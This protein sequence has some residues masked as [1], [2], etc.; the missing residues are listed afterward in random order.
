MIDRFR[1]VA[2]AL[3]AVLLLGV[4]GAAAQT[5]QSPTS[6]NPGAVSQ[7][8]SPTAQ[9]PAQPAGPA[10]P[11]INIA[12][13]T[14]RANRDV[15]VNIETA[16]NGWQHELDRLESALQ[17]PR[18]RYSELNDL[19]DELQRVRAG[20]EDFWKR[21]EPR[22][23][24][25]KDQVALL[26][27]A[28]A[29][30]QPPEPEQAALNRAELNY[31]FGLLSAGQAAVHS[32]NLRI[33]HLINTI[34]DIR[35]KNFT[36][37][38]FQPV[39]GIYSYQT[40][41]KLPDYVPSATNRVRD[42][43]ADWWD[44]IRDRNEVLLI[45]FETVLLWLVLTVAAW[46]GV[47]RLRRWRHEG[48]PPF[49]RRAS[50]AAGIILLRILPVVAPI[51][52]LYGMIAEAHALPERVDWIFYS[53]A[54][55]IIII[56]AVN[57]LVTTVFAP[58]SSQWRLIPASDQAA[59]RICGLVL[60]LA[61]V[62]GVT[63]LIYVITRLVQAPFAL[64]VA[65]ALPASLLLAGIVVAILLTP[66][67]GQHWDR[68]PSLRWLTALRIP[69]WITVAAIV[70]CALGG[71]LA[72]SR[73]LAQQLIVTG[74][75][76]AFV[77][78]LLLWVDGFMQG[79]GDDSAATGRWLKE[80]AGLERRRREQL[81]LPIGLFLKFAVLVFSV[82]LILLQW[83][84]RWPDI[85]DWYSQLF[86][87]FQIGNTQVSFAV[88]LAS[89]IVFGLAY[90]ATRLFQGWLD[91]RI[92]KPAGI[93]GGVR[94]SIRI[95]VGY[96]GIVIAGLA[97]FSY[98]G[99]NLS[100]LAILAGALSVGI[101]FG[102]QSVVNNFVS[103][104][105]LLAER[106][107][108]VGD[109]VVVGGEEGYVRKI[110]VRSTEVETS[111]RARVLIPNSYFITEKVKNW[112]LRDNTRRIVI[113]ISVGYGCDPRKVRAT[114]LKVAQ[115][116]P[117]VMTTPA[118]SVDFDFGADTLNFKV[119]AFVDDLSKGGSTSTD[120]RIAILDA[121]NEAGIA[122][123]FRQTDAT[124]QNTDWLR[125]AV[126]EYMAGSHNGTASGNGKASGSTKQ[127]SIPAI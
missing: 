15:G 22:L 28:P 94:D 35:R 58:R 24:A 30:G 6:Q 9:A 34:Q 21:L 107:I 11:Q 66:L 50:S 51:T 57:A 101:G 5:A 13:I 14:A 114:L 108:K 99:F 85:Y 37:N 1:D 67:D 7:A 106:P 36:T 64:T 69:I 122:M 80:R 23:A 27:P 76:L 127:A 102:L 38:L 100:N 49:W 19:R 126:A 47:R 83:G 65:V 117:D 77:Y 82:P 70:V 60:T 119:Y 81:V 98:A 2:R 91:A 92:L 104:L 3:V 118:P 78:L 87:G 109:L 123:P 20:I 115:D 29:A 71:Y 121:F 46:H 120:L 111:E 55:S 41:A 31:H 90:A 86:F 125:E 63:T 124:P 17:K 8:G 43:V 96:V 52:F 89:I 73:F 32:A 54:Q 105:I 103:G 79:L 72:L 113:P 44:S 39:P 18:L 53:T 56:F 61:I 116:D 40:W 95:G 84:Y 48:E 33:D 59:A 110:S 112:T 45:A 10:G 62:Y 4:A 25:A 74:S 42:L 97:A 16:I 26:G 12:E 75:I 93:S 68:T 88:L